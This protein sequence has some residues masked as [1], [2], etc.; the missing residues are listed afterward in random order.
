MRW[1][2]RQV[3][4]AVDLGD[5]V[6]VRAAA[7]SGG[8]AVAGTVTEA[9]VLLVHRWRERRGTGVMAAV[10]G[11]QG[12][13]VLSLP[14][15]SSVL[16]AV[17]VFGFVLFMLMVVVRGEAE[18]GSEKAVWWRQDGFRWR[19]EGDGGL[20]S[21]DNSLREKTRKRGRE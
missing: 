15:F 20:R 5:G 17:P 7:V 14:L 18:G 21:E 8:S 4:G 3:M 11:G 9:V 6:A 19:K 1:R 16:P 10:G 2:R 12:L 13:T